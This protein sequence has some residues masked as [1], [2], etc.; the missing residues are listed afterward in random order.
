MPTLVQINATCNWGSTGRIAEQIGLL[1]SKHGWDCYIAHGARYVRES[2]LK[3]ILVGSK[4]DNTLHAI[5]SKMLG[6]HGLGSIK[7]TRKL[8]ETLSAI[9]PDIVH[10]HNIHGYY[11]NY[12]I[13]F[14]YLRKADI[15]VVWTLHDCWSMTGHCTHFDRIGCERWKTGC[16]DCPQKNAQYETLLL[17]NC[18][19]NWILKKESFTS[20]NNLTMVPVSNWLRDIVRQSYLK[21]CNIKVINNG[22]DLSIFH[23][24]K[25]SLRESLNISI[26]KTIILGVA[27][28]WDEEKG[29][30]EFMLLSKNP[31]Y[32]VILIGL[33]LEQ[34][35]SMPKD[36]IAIQ[37]T[38]NQQELVE[39]YCIADMLVNPTY[40]DTFPTVNIEAL[41]CGTPVVTY[42]TG[43]SPEI[44]SEDT[45]LVVDR[46]DYKALVRAIETCR[47]NG[48][49]HYFD[50]CVTRAQ[51]KYNKD[52]RFEDYIRLYDSLLKAE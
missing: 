42:R 1:A 26:D 50:A 25:T 43:G 28:D 40:N 4:T 20:I 22:I 41:A 3:T 46:G 29:L 23:P 7:A 47:E 14:D 9:K 52:E 37:R 30:V 32:Q 17:N 51:T 49:S 8:V 39:Y 21:G 11:V 36:M 48:K 5:K 16:Y 12:Q 19:R 6:G 10:L 33:T 24:S 35:K 27:T 34:V 2:K 38:S 13:F 18:K 44:L 15:P 45:G 31:K